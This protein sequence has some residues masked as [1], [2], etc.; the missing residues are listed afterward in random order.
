MAEV[1][2]PPALTYYLSLAAQL[3]TAG[4]VGHAIEPLTQAARLQPGNAG[5]A[6]DLGLAY[7]EC[8]Q[9]GEAI[10]ALRRAVALRPR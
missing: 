9:I 2:D 1:T 7:L 6:H 4:K 5:I 8:G 10:A 3:L